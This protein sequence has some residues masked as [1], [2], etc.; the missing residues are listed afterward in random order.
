MNPW[1][2]GFKVRVCYTI[3][4]CKEIFWDDGTV[5]HPG[6]GDLGHTTDAIFKTYGTAQ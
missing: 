6:C 2:P 5:S 3:K 1:F 4:R